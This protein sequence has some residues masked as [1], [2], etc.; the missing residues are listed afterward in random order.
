[1]LGFSLGI[2]MMKMIFPYSRYSG[3]VSNI[4]PL[5][6]MQ[7]FTI[8]SILSMM[9]LKKIAAYLD[10]SLGF[11]GGDA[12]RCKSAMPIEEEDQRTYQWTAAELKGVVIAVTADTLDLSSADVRQLIATQRRLIATQ[13]D[14]I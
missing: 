12:V 7:I 9:F 14:N 1:M 5:S 11:S 3:F 2:P 4:L 10:F 13:H 6:S 8:I